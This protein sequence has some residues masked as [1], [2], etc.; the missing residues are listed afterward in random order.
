VLDDAAEV[1]S[2]L[3]RALLSR[4]EQG[5]EAGSPLGAEHVAQRFCTLAAEDEPP[6][7]AAVRAACA[8]CFVYVGDIERYRQ[9]HLPEVARAAAPR[10]GAPPAPELQL[11][12]AQQQNEWRAAADCYHASLLV[13]P[14][15]GRPRALRL[16]SRP[17]PPAPPPHAGLRLPRPQWGSAHNQLA[18]LAA[19]RGDVA[20]AVMHY[21]CALSS[22]K[23][24]GVA[25]DNLLAF[26]SKQMPALLR[27]PGA[28]SEVAARAPGAGGAGRGEPPSAVGSLCGVAALLFA[29]QQLLD[30]ERWLQVCPFHRAPPAP[31]PDSRSLVP[32]PLA[33]R[34]RPQGIRRARDRELARL[35][36]RVRHGGLEPSALQPLLVSSVCAAHHRL[37]SPSP[38]GARRD[39]ASTSPP[40]EATVVAVELLLSL[41]LATLHPLLQPDALSAAAPAGED[42]G[43]GGGGGAAVDRRWCQL[44]CGLLPPLLWLSATPEAFTHCPPHSPLL[45]SLGDALA[46]VGRACGTGARGANFGPPATTETPAHPTTNPLTTLHVRLLGLEP[47]R[48][49]LRQATHGQATHAP[50]VADG[51]P[52]GVIT[53]LS[54]AVR[55]CLWRLASADGVPGCV[56][57]PILIMAPA[58]TPAWAKPLGGGTGTADGR[59][60]GPKRARTLERP[61]AGVPAAPTGSSSTSAR[62][63]GRQRL[64]F[65][66]L[67]AWLQP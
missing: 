23:P 63:Q 19:Y 30:D 52:A 41:L 51:D 34:R 22:R 56:K 64:D 21:L 46:G 38:A 35:A 36:S 65:G 53:A 37:V 61:F 8:R 45:R 5:G 47:L 9:L 24:F 39:A 60:C 12:G 29:E 49:A 15:V 20:T 55:D 32:D 59:P 14:Q 31:R 66:L 10:G 13:A 62:G 26:V 54:A 2:Q 33:S 18:V 67:F 3:L 48:A 27:E 50:G 42:T 43:G 11:L 6:P 16:S 57:G 7:A 1:Y 40:G 4:L 25:R 28:A 44:L 17:A 58:A